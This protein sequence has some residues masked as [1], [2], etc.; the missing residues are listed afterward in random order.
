MIVIEIEKQIW[1]I[2]LIRARFSY[3][4]DNDLLDSSFVSKKTKQVL[5][6]ASMQQKQEYKKNSVFK[7]KY[8]G[9]L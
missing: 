5:T 8:K 6:Q 9:Q 3:T 7:L 4:E 1:R 2:T